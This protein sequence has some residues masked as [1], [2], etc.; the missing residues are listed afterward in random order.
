MTNKIQQRSEQH[1]SVETKKD[2]II[3]GYALRFER[4]KLFEDDGLDYYEQIERD[5]LEG[6]DFSDMSL[7]LNHTG[8]VSAR[9]RNGSLTFKIDS[10]GLYF[11]ADVS[12]TEHGRELYEMVKQGLYYQCSWAFTIDSEDYDVKTRTRIIKKVK[13]VYDVSVV[14]NGA[15]SNTSVSAREVFTGAEAQ[16]FMQELQ[17]RNDLVLKYMRKVGQLNNDIIR[18]ATTE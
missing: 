11:R 12:N 3:E 14:E 17:E 10:N 4:Y 18:Q 7:K 8:K 13:K 5:A 9:V 1:L 2:Y 16:A 15:N 6:A